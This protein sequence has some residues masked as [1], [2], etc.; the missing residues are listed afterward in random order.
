MWS[1]LTLQIHHGRYFERDFSS[2]VENYLSGLTKRGRCFQ[3]EEEGG[4]K[5]R[6]LEKS[7]FLFKYSRSKLA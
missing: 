4:Q 1:Y 3:E 5:I 6:D 2:G 7:F